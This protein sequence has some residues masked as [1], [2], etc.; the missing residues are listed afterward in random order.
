MH[1]GHLHSGHQLNGHMH[2]GHQHNGRLGLVPSLRQLRFEVGDVEP[3]KAPRG[4]LVP[5]PPKAPLPPSLAVAI[6]KVTDPELR[7]SLEDAA[8]RNLGFEHAALASR[9]PDG[10]RRRKRDAPRLAT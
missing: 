4:P 5:A 6:A 10:A 9:P 1:N 7:A 8:A 2:S 3:L